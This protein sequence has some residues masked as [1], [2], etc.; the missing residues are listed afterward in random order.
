MKKI[1]IVLV[2]CLLGAA[3]A[4][5]DFALG[6]NGALYMDDSQ[7]EAATGRSI[8]EAFQDGEGIYY[9]LMGE[10]MGKRMG[11]GLQFLG[12]WYI[13]YWG[14]PLR[15]LDLNLYLS[16]HLLGSR[17]VIDPMV[18]AGLGYI[19]KDWAKSS[20]DDDPD[21]PI[22]ASV[23]GYLGAGVG[24]NIWRLGIYSKFIWHFPIGHVMGTGDLSGIPIEEFGLKPYK[25]LIG[26]KII[27]G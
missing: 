17:F 7:L 12:S 16:A 11:L 8:A 18:D 25:I 24:L 13:S 4:F 14:D 9:G 5:A 27:L 21:N 20:L 6:L 15:D 1:M 23:Y 3:G 22:A 10:F 2:L 26:A 19:W